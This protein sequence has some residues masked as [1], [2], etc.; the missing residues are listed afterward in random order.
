MCWLLQLL[1]SVLG[2]VTHSLCSAYISIKRKEECH[3]MCMRIAP[4]IKITNLDDLRNLLV[5]ILASNSLEHFLH[6]CSP[7]PPIDECAAYSQAL[8][9]Y[10]RR[11]R[12]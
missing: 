3:D 5:L 6:N 4:C 10:L 12:E 8:F 9:L 7:I 2:N 1:R 11:G